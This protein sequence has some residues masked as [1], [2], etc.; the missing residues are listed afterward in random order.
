MKTST[1][2][3]AMIY[4]SV[5]TF[6]FYS[7]DIICDENTNVEIFRKNNPKLVKRIFDE[8]LT[9][10]QYEL[11]YNQIDTAIVAFIQ[12]Y[13]NPQSVHNTKVYTTQKQD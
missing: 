5:A 9:V 13:R 1:Q 7:K 4:F 2:Y 8:C 3:R 11:S 10:M 12:S 6:F